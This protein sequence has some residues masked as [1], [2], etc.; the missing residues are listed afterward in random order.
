MK[1][2][3]LLKLA[4]IFSFCISLISSSFVPPTVAQ[5][6]YNLQVQRLAG[7][8]K[9]ATSLE[10]CKYGWPG[11][12]KYAVIATGEDFPD[13]LSAAPLA[14]K[15]NAPIILIEKN[16]LR[17]KI[18]EEIA[19]LKVKNIFIIGGTSVISQNVEDQLVKRGIVVNRICGIDR[20]ET[21]LKV[22]QEVG[23]EEGVVIATGSNFADALSIAP[24]A[25][26]KGMPILLTKRDN[27]QDTVTEYLTAKSIS[28]AYVIGGTAVVSENIIHALPHSKRLAG[29]TQY[30][31]NIAIL[32]EFR[33]DLNLNT[34]F[35]ATGNNF[36]DAL[37]GSVLAAN[38]NSPTILIDR[39]INHSTK[40]YLISEYNSIQKM[41]VLGGTSVI[42]DYVVSSIINRFS[43]EPFKEK[44]LNVAEISLG[45]SEKKVIEI[46]GSPLTK[47]EFYDEA[48]HEN[49]MTLKYS[50][51]EVSLEHPQDDKT[52]VFW[53]T[54]RAPGICGPRNTFV[55]DDISLV[56]NRF[57]NDD[58]PVEYNNGYM[59]KPLYGKDYKYI[60]G[61]YWG[62]ASCDQSGNLTSVYYGIDGPGFGSYGL[63]YMVNN[64]KV[65]EYS[66]G[67]GIM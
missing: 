56:L 16:S 64:G 55:G 58:Y 57:R 29:N 31:T 8:D 50:W 47:S 61:H 25:A 28:K 51:G 35:L 13:A 30:D 23:V 59:Y 26:I 60:D 42:D 12:S 33:G 17:E 46:M 44:D 15:Y 37:S 36:P 3:K 21:S 40:N 34:V 24:V 49:I 27:L 54:V 38:S 45:M 52:Y 6:A 63:S 1:K 32:K 62:S 10:I 2:I 14:K 43:V 9:Y 5:S 66:I 7:A 48:C 11:S 20:Y 67:L 41:M 22:A 65:M 39:D 19:R 18:Y 53:I 4:M